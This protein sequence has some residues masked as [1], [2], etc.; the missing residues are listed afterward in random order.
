MFPQPLAGKVEHRENG[1]PVTNQ[2]IPVYKAYPAKGHEGTNECQR[3][4]SHSGLGGAVPQGEE[5]PRLTPNSAPYSQTRWL[6]SSKQ[7]HHVSEPHPG[8]VDSLDV[9]RIWL[10]VAAEVAGFQPEARDHVPH[11]CV[12]QLVSESGKLGHRSPLVR[13]WS[14]CSACAHRTQ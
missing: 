13:T 3:P 5:M 10:R 14:A 4:R 6:G 1:T 2:E 12:A 11:R 8:E 7:Q 9:Y